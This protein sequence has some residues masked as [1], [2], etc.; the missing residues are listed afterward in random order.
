MSSDGPTIEHRNTTGTTQMQ[1]GKA[2]LLTRGD[3][4]GRTR[5]KRQ[6]DALVAGLESDLGGQ[7]NITV[8]QRQLIEHAAVT[9][10]IIEHYGTQWLAGTPIDVTGYLAAI[11][12]QRR[13]L[14]TLGL[15]RRP[16]DVTP[17]LKGYLE[18]KAA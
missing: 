6:A 3:L 4:D 11:N 14:V 8:A 12:A 13:I 2:R 10:A 5:A 1:G 17:D 9:G 7:D 18:G 15:Y 16:R